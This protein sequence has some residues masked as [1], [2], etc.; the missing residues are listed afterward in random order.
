MDSAMNLQLEVISELEGALGEGSPARSA[1]IVRKLTNQFLDD[2]PSYSEEQIAL[3]DGV[4]SRLACVIETSVKAELARRMSDAPAAAPK[5]LRQLA[6]DELIEV[7]A[8]LLAGS[9]HLGD[10]VLIECAQCRG[11]GHLL[12]IAQRRSVSEAVTDELV[13]RGEAQVLQT[14]VGNGGSRFSNMG[15]AT[16]VLRAENSDVLAEGIGARPDLP[17]HHF[18]RLL[19]AASS[20]VREKL[21]AANPQNAEDIRTIVSEVTRAIAARAAG[22][23]REYNEALN[24]VGALKAAGELGD[25]EIL[26]F[27]ADQKYEFVVAAIAVLADLDVASVNHAIMQKRFETVLTIARAIGL[28]WPTVRMLLQLRA[29]SA[30]LS[31]RELEQALA[32]FSRLKPETARQALSLKQRN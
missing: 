32:S 2:S 17:R 9:E 21:E 20:A 12:A 10:M 3:F 13:T 14:I 15:Y 6:L 18:L 28:G 25:Y 16:L 19:A 4:L 8:P 30:A 24:R 5:L 31:A 7:A 22:E 29:G 23:S 11:Q 27:A 1:S 26:R